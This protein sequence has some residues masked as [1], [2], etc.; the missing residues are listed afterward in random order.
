M[1]SPSHNNPGK[2]F[3]LGQEMS[4]GGKKPPLSGAG[5]SFGTDPRS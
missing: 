4:N 1:G 2:R 5:K 3:T